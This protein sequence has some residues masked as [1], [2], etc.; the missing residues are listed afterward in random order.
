VED[1]PQRLEGWLE[2]KGR[3]GVVGNDW[4]KRYVRIDEANATLVYS[5]SSE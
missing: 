2:K 4:Q 1:K 5:K 3:G